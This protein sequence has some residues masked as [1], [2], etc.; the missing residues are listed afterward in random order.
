MELRPS[1]ITCAKH[2]TSPPHAPAARC[3]GPTPRLP[4][5]P[6]LHLAA[7]PRH[8]TRRRAGQALP[9]PLGARTRCR[10]LTTT[11]ST[12]PKPCAA[13]RRPRRTGG[14]GAAAWPGSLSSRARRKERE[15]RVWPCTLRWRLTAPR[16]GQGGAGPG[17]PD[18][19]DDR[20]GIALHR[21]E[22]AAVRRANAHGVARSPPT[23]GKARTIAR[24]ASSRNAQT[25]PPSGSRLRYSG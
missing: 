23:V 11:Q 12:G 19:R 3:P 14:V 8:G 4:P 13:G 6:A 17:L 5:L 24:S 21:D 10:E 15:R 16:G 22:E 25:A 2:P 9:R 20:M 7:Q 1:S 18:A